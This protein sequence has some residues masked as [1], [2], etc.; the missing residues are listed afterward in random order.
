MPGRVI[1]PGIIPSFPSADSSSVTQA[2]EDINTAEDRAE[3][4]QYDII[5]RYLGLTKP[6]GLSADFEAVFQFDQSADDLND[7]TTNGHDLAVISGSP[8]YARSEA[9]LYYKII[10]RNACLRSAFA[11]LPN[12]GAGTMDMVIR[13]YT[14]TTDGDDL[15]FTLGH[16]GSGAEAD[17]GQMA[18]RIED[19]S[20]RWGGW[21]E[22]GGG[23]PN[24]AWSNWSPQKYR[25]VYLA[26]TR[27]EDGKTY[28]LFF[29]GKQAGSSFAATNA[30]TGG[31]NVGFYIG[32]DTANTEAQCGVFC[33]RYVEEEM[34]AAMILAENERIRAAF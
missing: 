28:K 17:N 10:D 7:R 31:T 11:N 2:Q 32:W 25:E 23:T 8:L 22:N 4:L 26:L 19:T 3:T 34:T 33:A 14:E 9:G 16:S 13:W 24:Y 29:D 27:N 15:L 30:P 1:S 6:S 18:I 21:H 5:K 12:H 20:G